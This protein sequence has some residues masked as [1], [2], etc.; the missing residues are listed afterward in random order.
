VQWGQVNS[1]TGALNGGEL[2]HDTEIP[3]DGYNIYFPGVGTAGVDQIIRGNSVTI[4]GVPD[5]KFQ[6]WNDVEEIGGSSIAVASA[7]ASTTELIG[8][9]GL[10]SDHD[11]E[12]ATGVY[13]IV[14]AN[15]SAMSPNET[16]GVYGINYA[17]E[18]GWEIRQVV[19]IV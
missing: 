16:R 17:V 7:I 8:F 5:A 4:T 14:Q 12:N 6:V 15:P 19:N 9:L 10:V 13:G 3:T 18:S 1:G 11:S 2:I